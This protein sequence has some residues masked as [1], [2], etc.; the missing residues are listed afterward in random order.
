MTITSVAHALRL[1]HCLSIYVSYARLSRNGI[2]QSKRLSLPSA[3]HAD[4]RLVCVSEQRAASLRRGARC[5]L[6]RPGDRSLAAG[7]R[8]TGCRAAVRPCAQLKG[9]ERHSHSRRRRRRGASSADA[10]LARSCAHTCAAQARSA[11]RA[12]RRGG[13]WSK[14]AVEAEL[15]GAE[16]GDAQTEGAPLVE[17]TFDLEDEVFGGDAQGALP[18]G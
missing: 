13:E 5:T 1:P 15:A 11:A 9:L 17:A 12:Q 2:Q 3:S 4:A 18:R 10:L 14:E 16:E 7:Q 6:V 8:T